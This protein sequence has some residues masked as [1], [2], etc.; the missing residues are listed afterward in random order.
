MG[1]LPIML[2]RP[3]S[4]C[5]LSLTKMQLFSQ[6]PHESL[7]CSQ[8]HVGATPELA[9]GEVNRTPFGKSALP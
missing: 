1:A 5:P 2:Q 3:G 6:K 8:I 7:K 4:D 9:R